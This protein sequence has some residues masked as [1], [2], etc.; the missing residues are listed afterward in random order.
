MS[1]NSIKVPKSLCFPRTYKPNKWSAYLG[2]RLTRHEHSI[3]Q[4]LGSESYMNGTIKEL[5]QVCIASGL[6]VAGLTN[7]HGNCL[8]ESLIYHK[9]GSDVESLRVGLASLMY[10]F[11][12]MKDF[13]PGNDQTIKELFIPFNEIEYSQGSVPVKDGDKV[14]WEHDY[15]K[16][17]FTVML[18][19]LSNQNCWNDLPTQLVL[20]IISLVYKAKIYIVHSNGH[21]TTINMYEGSDNSP[22]LIDIHLGLLGESHYMPVD[23]AGPDDSIKPPLYEEALGNFLKWAKEREA[24][25]INDWISNQCEKTDKVDVNKNDVNKND[26]NKNDVHSQSK[27]NI[28]EVNPVES[29]FVSFSK[30]IADEFNPNTDT[31]ELDP[32]M[33]INMGVSF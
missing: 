11:G 32:N 26:V 17:D 31:E 19:Q 33:D 2:R 13:F 30:T 24:E 1:T 25:K 9:I 22:H 15:Y 23:F 12:N 8:F 14:Q 18:Q 27:N 16:Y 7:L 6:R 29:S 20:H 10:I 4:D 21:V 28:P 5:Q 3:L